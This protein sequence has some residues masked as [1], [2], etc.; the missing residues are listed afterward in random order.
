MR[1]KNLKFKYIFMKKYVIL[2]IDYKGL[3]E[4]SNFINNIK[5]QNFKNFQLFLIFN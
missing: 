5:N 1:K 3:F 4:F 2:S